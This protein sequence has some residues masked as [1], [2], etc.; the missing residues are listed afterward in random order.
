M[1][2]YAK[3][4]RCEDHEGRIDRLEHIVDG[5]GSEGIKSIVYRHERHFQTQW[6]LF[7]ALAVEIAGGFVAGFLL[8]YFR[9]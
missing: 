5:N 3:K 6:K 2:D 9:G 1:D 7:A 4:N 8:L